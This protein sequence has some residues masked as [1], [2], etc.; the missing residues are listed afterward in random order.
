MID[1][2]PLE[3]YQTCSDEELD[4]GYE[5][6]DAVSLMRVAVLA[7]IHGNLPALDAVLGDINAVG[8]DAIVLNRAL[9]R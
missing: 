1:Q 9:R 2:V 8:V 6:T 5:N 4:P 3:V 7:D